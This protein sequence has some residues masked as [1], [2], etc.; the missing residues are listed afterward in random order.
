M[1][2]QEFKTSLNFMKTPCVKSKEKQKQNN[3]KQKLPK[4]R[5]GKENLLSSNKQE[6]LPYNH[7]YVNVENSMKLIHTQK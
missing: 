5:R 3:K 6:S 1:E 7:R 2:H 4:H